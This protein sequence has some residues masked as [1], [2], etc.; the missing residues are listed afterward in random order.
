MLDKRCSVKLGHDGKGRRLTRLL[1]LAAAV[2]VHWAPPAGAAP[3]AGTEGVEEA[4][5]FA[6]V[7]PSIAFVRGRDLY[8]GTR[9]L[10]WTIARRA[11][12][13]RDGPR[14]RRPRRLRARREPD[15]LLARLRLAQ[16]PA[17]RSVQVIESVP[18][19]AQLGPTGMTLT[20]R[21]RPMIAY[22]IRRRDQ[23]TKL[24]RGPCQLARGA[25]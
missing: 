20:R 25:G 22:S 17:W 3:I 4:A 13:G 19:D 24:A 15:G 7:R 5:Y 14:R 12:L 6:G 18:K 21:G 23:A 8:A 1:P 16:Q 2:A 11:T 9:G 10:D